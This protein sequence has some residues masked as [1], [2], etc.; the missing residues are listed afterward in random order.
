MIWITNFPMPPSANEHL[1]AVK[2]RLVKSQKH[3]DFKRVC[4]LWY[5]Q[6]RRSIDP[7]RSK[8]MEMKNAARAR[9]SDLAL[10]VDAY[11]AVD[12]SRVFTGTGKCEQIDANNFLKPLLDGL[13]V[14]IGIDDKH[15]FAGN[16]EKVTT[17]SKEL[18]CSVVRITP[19]RPRTLEEIRALMRSE[20]NLAGS[21]SSK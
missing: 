2:G 4:E 18:E 14:V 20:T 19:T 15:F 11:I 5:L 3:R 16:C 10:K 17:S 6:N 13:V 21:S 7:I 9:G 1:F 12:R 8:L